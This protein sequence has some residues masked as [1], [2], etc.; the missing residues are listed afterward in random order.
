MGSKESHEVDGRKEG[1]VM[2]TDGAVIRATVW[3]D[4]NILTTVVVLVF[5]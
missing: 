3:V 1:Q 2:C 4:I 5:V